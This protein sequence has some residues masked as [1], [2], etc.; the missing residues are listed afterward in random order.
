METEP[1]GPIMRNKAQAKLSHGNYPHVSSRFEVQTSTKGQ[2]KDQNSIFWRFPLHSPLAGAGTVRA[3]PADKARHRRHCRSNKAA[4]YP[5]RARRARAGNAGSLWSRQKAAASPNQLL[6]SHAPR[7][8]ARAASGRHAAPP[9]PP[10]LK[11]TP[12]GCS[13]PAPCT[14]G[15]VVGR[16]VPTAPPRGRRLAKNRYRR[17]TKR[18]RCSRCL[19]SPR[20]ATEAAAPQTNATK[21]LHAR[22]V[23]AGSFCGPPVL[24]AHPWGRRLAKTRYR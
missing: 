17:T 12:Q 7:A 21:L 6:I 1:L 14:P 8:A 18:G 11:Q 22:A 23:H 24:T 16:Q 20:S 4:P 15:P 5:R 3:T 2:P 10:P 13:M 19:G 9:K